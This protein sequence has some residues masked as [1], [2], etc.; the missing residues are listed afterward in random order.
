[1]SG[2]LRCVRGFASASG[3]SRSTVALPSTP[4]E[5]DFP[6]REEDF[7][8]D[9]KHWFVKVDKPHGT[10]DEMIAHYVKIFTAFTGNEE[11]ARKKI[12]NVST[13]YYYAFG[14]LI[15]KQEAERLKKVPLVLDVIPDAYVNRETKDYGST[16][17][18]TNMLYFINH[19]YLDIQIIFIL[20]FMIMFLLYFYTGEP[21]IDGQP[22]PY[23]PKYHKF[24]TDFRARCDAR[25]AAREE[26]EAEARARGEIETDDEDDDRISRECKSFR[27]KESLIYCCILLEVAYYM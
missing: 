1:M 19:N 27:S 12:Y 17:V 22:V 24:Y 5:D 9:Y 15:S 14:V 11:E 23:D 13:R 18:T 10:R 26:E 2:L 20:Y 25:R 3:Y 8:T 7:G 21:F 6:V 4:T 16:V